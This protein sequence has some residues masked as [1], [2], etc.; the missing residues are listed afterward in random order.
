VNDRTCSARRARLLNGT[1][2]VALCVASIVVA[3]GVC[4]PGDALAQTTVNPGQGGTQTT[5]FTLTAGQNPITFGGGT[6]VDTSATVGSDAVT[7]DNTTTWNVTVDAQAK[8]KG[9]RRGISLDPAGITLVNSGTI[10][11]T[12]TGTTGDGAVFLANGGA[13]TNLASGKINAGRNGIFGAGGSTTVENFGSIT[14]TDS[15]GIGVAGSVTS[16][17]N[18]TG[19]KISSGGDGISLNSTGASIINEQGATIENVGLS[20]AGPTGSGVEMNGTL[21]NFGT[22]SARGDSAHPATAVQF[23]GTG[24]TLI[25]HTGSVL[26]GDAIGSTAANATNNLVLQGRGTADNNF[27][28]FQSLKVQASTGWTLNGS[29][30]V[31]TATIETG[32]LVVGSDGHTGAVLTGDVTVK[33]GTILSGVGKINGDVTVMNGGE[34]A[35]GSSTGTMNV[36]GHVGFMPGSTFFITAPPTR[37]DVTKLAVTGTATLGGAVKVATSGTGYAPSTQYT[38]LTASGGGLGGSNIFDSVTSNSVF[39]K[40]T[41]TYDANDV[42]LTLD[43][44]NSGAGGA[45]GTGNL[46]ATAAQTRN[47]TAVANAFDPSAATNP[48]VLALLNQTA[49]GARQAFDALSGEVF[50]SVHNVQ[51]G[52]TQFA[53]SAMLGRLRQA[54][55][56]GYSGELNALAF[57]GPELA[58][59]GDNANAAYAADIGPA[60]PGKAP[61]RSLS[62]MGDR[63]R[64]LTF[65]AQGLGG[66]GHADSDGNAASLRSRF[67]GFLS[68]VDARFG[69]MVRAGFT[70]GYIRSDLNADARASSA[71]IDSVQI[72]A[73]AGGKLGA[74]NVRGGASYSFDSIDVSRGIFFPGFTDQTKASFRGNVGQVFGEVGYGMTLGSVAV[75]PL[76]GLAYVHVHDNSFA[77]SGGAAALS[78][79]SARENL[80]YSFLGARA[81]TVIPLANGTAL[82]PRASV[83]WQYAFG[84]VT[85]VSA[86]AFQGTGTGFSVAGVPIARNTALVEAGFDWRFSPWAK[87]GAFYQGELA[88]HAQTHAV[89][90]GL[91]WN[92]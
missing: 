24:N 63:S 52:E 88:A 36:T 39:L 75:E 8:I 78:G 57:G 28:G 65:W 92:F 27:S 69:D 19:A 5:T 41:L 77:E 4:A 1:S 62:H 83:Q 15:F 60:M 7:G 85:P 61:A 43:L 11:Q 90:G 26:I 33:I 23:F 53:R 21:D 79:A 45:G 81:A 12:D 32:E 58:Y 70:A 51:A 22:I 6:D 72:G 35:P 71:G 86:L 59:A 31:G 17:V 18:R 74:L 47:Q 56:G 16:L 89:K 67:A 2:N 87:L 50:G 44:L 80:G 9:N 84:D 3:L 25:L 42:F 38:I 82:V 34:L 29:V 46:F 64:D 40:P 54:S 30:D 73:Y 13:V 68:G 55:Y 14:A 76:A 49:D 20:A 66:W 91:T 10:S 37:T 48:V